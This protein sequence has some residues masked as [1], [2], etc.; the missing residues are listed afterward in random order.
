MIRK[1]IRTNL[2]YNICSR[3]LNRCFIRLEYDG[4]CYSTLLQY[5]KCLTYILFARYDRELL[6]LGFELCYV[7]FV[8]CGHGIGLDW[9]E[10]NSETQVV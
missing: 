8:W 4:Q 7:P 9:V 1:Q 5:N 6:I 3:E 10:S 2:E